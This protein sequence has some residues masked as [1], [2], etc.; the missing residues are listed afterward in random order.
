VSTHTDLADLAESLVPV[1]VQL[2]GA[3]HDGGTAEVGR[4]LHGVP[5]AELPALCVVLA[6]MTDPDLTPEQMLSWVTWEEQPPI[7]P[8]ATLFADL[9]IPEDRPRPKLDEVRNELARPPA[10]WSDTTCRRFHAAYTRGAQGDEALTLAGEREYQRRRK[11]V[12]RQ[13]TRLTAPS[14]EVS[15]SA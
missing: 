10:E 11:A 3:V 9:G 12:N 2:I 1:A 13:A 8:E 15:S 4:V 6:A 14:T 7:I 5:E